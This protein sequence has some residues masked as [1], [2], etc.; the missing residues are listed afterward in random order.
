MCQFFSCLVTRDHRVLFCESVSHE[1]LIRRTGLD[2]TKDVFL[3]SWV[4]AEVNPAG[5]TGWG[6]VKVDETSVPSWW[7]EIEDSDRVLIVANTVR[8]AEEV[9]D[10]AVRSAEEVYD[11]A[12]RSAQEVYTVAE[13]S[14]QE[15]YNAA[16][17]SA[18]KVYNAADYNAA[19][20]PAEEV[21]TVAERSAQEVYNAA[22]WSAKEVYTVA[23]ERSDQ[24]VYNAAVWSAREAYVASISARVGYL[25]KGESEQKA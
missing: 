5:T 16:E 7:D 10:A 22:V 21:Y 14:A 11:A 18:R 13:R 19:V 12:V 1:E 17:R 2:D 23:A 25:S 20:R 3:R 15:V 24:E 8:S 6:R 9:Y 4:R